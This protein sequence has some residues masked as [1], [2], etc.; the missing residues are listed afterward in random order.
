MGNFNKFDKGRGD[1]GFGGGSFGGR[2]KFGRHNDGPRQMFSATC[3]E[4][5]QKCEVPFKPTGERPIYCNN[6]FKNHGGPSQRFAPRGFDS[7]TRPSTSPTGGALSLGGQS[8]ISKVQFDALNA[9]LDKII[10]LLSP[11]S[12]NNSAKTEEISK[13]AVLELKNKKETTKKSKAPAK[14]TKRKK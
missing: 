12:T 3:S 7:S 14:K 5:G 4:C 9:K 13:P 10:S 8:D 1:R 2:G 11:A 6:C